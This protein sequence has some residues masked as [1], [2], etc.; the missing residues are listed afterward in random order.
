MCLMA[1]VMCLMAW[2]AEIERQFILDG[3]KVDL[4][5]DGRGCRDVRHFAIGTGVVSN[6]SNITSEIDNT[7]SW[8]S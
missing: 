2:I 3:V 6:T 4:R 7:Q 8:S 5:A 1:W